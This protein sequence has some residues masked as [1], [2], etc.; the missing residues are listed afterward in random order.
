MKNVKLIDAMITESGFDFNQVKKSNITTSS[1]INQKNL[2][3]DILDENSYDIKNNLVIPYKME[4]VFKDSLD[5]ISLEYLNRYDLTHSYSIYSEHNFDSYFR[6]LKNFKKIHY[7][8]FYYN[9]LDYFN[10]RNTN[11][12]SLVECLDKSDFCTLLFNSKSPIS[13]R[14]IKPK[15][16]LILFN[17]AYNNLDY[18]PS[19]DSERVFIRTNSH[20]SIN[21]LDVEYSYISHGFK[22]YKKFGDNIKEIFFI[23]DKKTLY[24][25]IETSEELNYYINHYLKPIESLDPR[26]KFIINEDFY[27][28]KYY[29]G[30]DRLEKMINRLKS[31]KRLSYKSFK[32]ELYA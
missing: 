29:K 26:I 28:L 3:N 10:P 27:P 18:Y 32:E 21:Y 23:I 13:D 15:N 31:S 5:E 30:Y 19:I 8:F 20:C 25:F 12:D 1:K 6:Q 24:S 17:N 16:C 9:L 22:K 4:I 14:T 7:F 11:I 2:L